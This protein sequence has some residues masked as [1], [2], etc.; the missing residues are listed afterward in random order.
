MDNYNIYRLSSTREL[1]AKRESSCK[2]AVLFGGLDYSVNTEV[3][4]T[5]Q[6]KSQLN[7]N[8]SLIY[9]GLSDSLFLRNS[10]E[11]LYDT[12][13]E[14]YEIDKT[15]KKGNV[16]V[17]LYSDSCGTEESFKALSGKGINLIH[18]ATH[19]MY[20]GAS[21]AEAMKRDA[22]LT[23]IQLD[24]KRSNRIQEDW[25]LSR[26][27]L[28]M[29]GGD[30][31]P[32]HKE[33]PEGEEDGILTAQEISTIDLRGLDLVVLS[34]CQTGLGDVISGEG[35][36]GLQR[37]FKKAG[38]NTILMSLD[39]V[40]DKATMIFMVEFYRSLMSGKTK[41]Q[42]LKDAQKYLRSVENGKYD[43]PEYWASFI[44]LDGLN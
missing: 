3:L 34:A 39:K 8:S 44:M 21:E 29:S 4:L 25:S 35:V 24:G 20:I 36:F 28:V 26:S 17:S 16:V 15:L 41:L 7:N 33:I 1:V 23:F 2:T 18:L 19:G 32:N 12:K 27:F 11:P 37:G 40:D 10:F 13:T 43:K 31:L 38:A 30:M 9:R 42:S 5:P 6:N 22:N 14:I